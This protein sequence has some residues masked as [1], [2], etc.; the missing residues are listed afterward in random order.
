MYKKMR[1]TINIL[2]LFF[3]IVIG[4]VSCHINDK[5]NFSFDEQNYQTIDTLVLPFQFQTS[6]ESS[7]LFKRPS[8]QEN[9][10]FDIV[11]PTMRARIYCSYLPIHGNF[12]SLNEDILRFVYR[13]TV[14]ATQIEKT[15]YSDL[16]NNVFGLLFEIDGPVASPLQFMVTDSTTHF[17]RGA[18]YF[19]DRNAD[20]VPTDSLAQIRA[21]MEHLIKTLSW[22][23]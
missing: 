3:F 21:D 5:H 12:R 8:E 1:R 22:R 13:H 15:P 9:Q 23:K 17:F 4:A 7:L 11:Y 2:S 18:L 20:A 19:D 14:V 6:C 16:K 10:W